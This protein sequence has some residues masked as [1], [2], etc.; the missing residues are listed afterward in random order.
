MA[1]EHQVSATCDAHVALLGMAD[2]PA[3]QEKIIPLGQGRRVDVCDHC[4]QLPVWAQL[5]ALMPWLLPLYELGVEVG[6]PKGRRA[7]KE[8]KAPVP[9]PESTP[10]VDEAPKV[11]AI[12][13][14][15]AKAPKKAPKDPKAGNSDRLYVIC[16][17]TAGHVTGKLQ[18]VFYSDRANHAGK[19]HEGVKPWDIS[20]LDPENKL[21]VPC[22]AHAECLKSGLKFPTQ[23]A[24]IRHIAG[25]T[26][27]RIDT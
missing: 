2:I 20:W 22:E 3:T 14:P 5:D 16:P 8:A 9:E 11:K 26:L 27:R 25:V 15:K 10:E 24:V 17:V 12:E 21:T 6:D 18:R 4:A 1:R 7:P 13:A 19:A 23:L